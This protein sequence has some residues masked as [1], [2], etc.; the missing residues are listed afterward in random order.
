MQCP[1]CNAFIDDDSRHCDQ[2]ECEKN[3]FIY[4]NI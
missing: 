2:C 1:F 4:L 3:I